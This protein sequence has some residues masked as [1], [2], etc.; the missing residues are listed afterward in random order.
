MYC[1]VF[2]LPEL[3][4]Q[5]NCIITDLERSIENLKYTIAA[6]YIEQYYECTYDDTY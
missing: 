5:Y 3:G 4:L 6:Y 2:N 1:N